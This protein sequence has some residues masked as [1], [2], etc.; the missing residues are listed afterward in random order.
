VAA[1]IMNTNINRKTITADGETAGDK[2]RRG[3]PFIE[4][5][6]LRETEDS[7]K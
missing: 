1:E 4:S 3:L 6:L 2:Q 7:A 5:M